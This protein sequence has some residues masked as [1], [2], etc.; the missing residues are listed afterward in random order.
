MPSETKPE[1]NTDRMSIDASAPKMDTEFQKFMSDPDPFRLIFLGSFAGVRIVYKVTISNV[2]GKE[3]KTTESEVKI[4]DTARIMNETG[5]DYLASKAM[6]LINPQATM[7]NVNDIQIYNAIRGT[8]RAL[9]HDLFVCYY[10]KNN[11]YNMDVQRIASVTTSFTT[12]CLSLSKAKDGFALKQLS[13]SFITTE[14]RRSGGVE[15]QRQ[16]GLVD[17]ITNVFKPHNQGN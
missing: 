2:L 17:R 5:A 6:F 11:P 7:S 16:T 15:Q 8:T 12:L 10:C 4:D 14:I 9:R 3:I 1:G 13:Q